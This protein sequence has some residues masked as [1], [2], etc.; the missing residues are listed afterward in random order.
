MEACFYRFSVN[1]LK[2][3]LQ[4]PNIIHNNTDKG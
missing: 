3:E 1:N 4:E 2:L